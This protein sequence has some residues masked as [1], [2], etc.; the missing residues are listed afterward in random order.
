MSLR[1]TI[2]Y[3]IITIIALAVVVMYYRYDPSSDGFFPKCLWLS[4]TG[5]RCP[6]CG[7]QRALHAMFH[8][9]II[10]ALRFNP[11]AVIA[12]VLISVVYLADRYREH[13]PNLYRFTMHPLFIIAL[14]VMVLAWWV[15]RN[16][17]DL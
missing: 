5:Y 9:H 8:G 12:P 1:R 17:F 2:K 6:G 13:C 16:V 4:L 10:D 11:L 14:L 15:L 7:T 3:I